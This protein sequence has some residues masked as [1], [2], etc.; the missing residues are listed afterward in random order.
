[1][2]FDMVAKSKFQ[3]QQGVFYDILIEKF[4]AYVGCQITFPGDVQRHVRNNKLDIRIQIEGKLFDTSSK[5]YK[6]HTRVC[7]FLRVQWCRMAS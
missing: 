2:F 1:M 7:S 4:D 3:D 5:K 6:K